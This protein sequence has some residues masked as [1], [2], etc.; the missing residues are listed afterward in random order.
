MDLASTPH[1]AKLKKKFKKKGPK[2]VGLSLFHM[3][4]ETDPVSETFCFLVARI[5]DDGQSPKNPII[6]SVIHHPENPS[7]SISSVVFQF[8]LKI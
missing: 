7:E 5:P 3:R 4:T 1:Y 6:L 2:R 8:F